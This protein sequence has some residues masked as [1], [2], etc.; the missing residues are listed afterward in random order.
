MAHIQHRYTYFGLVLY[1]CHLHRMRDG[2]RQ[3]ETTWEYK[4]TSDYQSKSL[5]MHI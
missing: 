4:P 3:N 1:R 2:E 5:F